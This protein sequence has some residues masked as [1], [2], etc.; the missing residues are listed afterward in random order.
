[1]S[2]DFISLESIE[3][4]AQQYGYWVIFFGILLENIGIPLP[5]ETVTLAGGFLAGSDQLNYWFVLGYAVLGAILGGNIGYWVGRYGGWPLML[6]VGRVFRVPESRLIAMKNQF[7]E[8][9]AK[10]V[11]LGRFVALLRVF[12]SPLAG[13]AEMPYPQFMLY[14]T[15]GAAAWASVMV[16]LSYFAGQFV[17]L[18]KLVALA[19]QFSAVVFVILAAWI[20]IP[21]WLESRKAAQVVKAATLPEEVSTNPQESGS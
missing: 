5:G 17:P 12:A 3:N 9:S 19:G 4:L 6:G 13:I 1:M 16:T 10:A 18:D 11:F 15:L 14:N 7:G 2:L 8:N 20:V 21:L